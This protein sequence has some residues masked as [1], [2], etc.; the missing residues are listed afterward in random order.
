MSVEK[1]ISRILVFKYL[2]IWVP[3]SPPHLTTWS[4]MPPL[5]V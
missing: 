1:Y 3:N 4:L 2:S 5:K